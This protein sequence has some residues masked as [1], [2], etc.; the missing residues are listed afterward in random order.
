[1]IK[2]SFSF[3]TCL[4]HFSFQPGFSPWLC[5]LSFQLGC[6]FSTPF[7]ASWLLSSEEKN[8]NAFKVWQVGYLIARALLALCIFIFL[9]N[10]SNLLVSVILNCTVKQNYLLVQD[11]ETL[12]DLLM[13]CFLSRNLFICCVTECRSWYCIN[14]ACY[15][16]FLKFCCKVIVIVFIELKKRPILQGST[17][18]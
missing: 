10:L 4:Y 8:W 1:M 15:I 3:L 18:S 12:D 13:F 11:P 14:C 17:P 9:H 16:Y 5:H 6:I 7:K 2:L